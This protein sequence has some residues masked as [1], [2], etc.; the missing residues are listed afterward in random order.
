M[1]DEFLHWRDRQV[2]GT[3]F[4]YTLFHLIKKKKRKERQTEKNY[5]K[6]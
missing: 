1:A 5:A 3:A 4:Y 6:R 2:F